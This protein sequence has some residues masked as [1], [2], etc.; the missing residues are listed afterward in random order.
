MVFGGWSS[1][2]KLFLNAF[3]SCFDGFVR[4]ECHFG[5]TVAVAKPCS[6]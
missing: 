3:R 5:F 4:V 2:L 1:D 6:L